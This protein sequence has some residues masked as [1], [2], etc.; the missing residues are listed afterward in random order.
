MVCRP[1]AGS[2]AASP[3]F[4]I[5][6]SHVV[7]EEEEQKFFFLGPFHLS[8]PLS[9]RAV[10]ASRQKALFSTR[11]DSPTGQKA[12]IGSERGR[13]V[14]RVSTSTDCSRAHTGAGRGIG[15]G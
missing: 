6:S 11:R 2:P 10:A 4:P 14:G 1:P 12:R 3:T 9:C 7:P 8:G 5:A 15:E 13:R